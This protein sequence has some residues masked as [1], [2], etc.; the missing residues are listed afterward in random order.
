MCKFCLAV[1][2]LVIGFRRCIKGMKDF[3]R[4]YSSGGLLIVAL[5]IILVISSSYALY[6]CI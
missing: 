1:L 4:T 5:G 6:L 2:I 3:D